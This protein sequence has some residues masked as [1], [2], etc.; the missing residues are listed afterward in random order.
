VA[1]LSVEGLAI[2]LQRDGGVTTLVEDTTFSLEAAEVM[3]LVGE[4]G[5]GK[6]IVCRSLT[7]LLPSSATQVTGGRAIFEGRDLLAMTEAE[8]RLVRG[9]RMAMVFQNPLSHLNP[10][11][12]IGQQIAEPLRLVEG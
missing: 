10:V 9:R 8:L 7:R 5:S 3:G 1:L 4:S 6:T 11:K 12:T 2:G